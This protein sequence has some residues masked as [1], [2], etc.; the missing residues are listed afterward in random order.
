MAKQVI[1]VKIFN[2][3]TGNDATI[4]MVNGNLQWASISGFA[5]WS[6]GFIDQNTVD[7]PG[8]AINISAGGAL[9][10]FDGDAEIDVT[11]ALLHN[12]IYSGAISVIGKQAIVAIGNDPASFDD[13]KIEFNGV[14]SSQG[15]PDEI[16]VSI[17]CDSSIDFDA[18]K[19]PET[20]ITQEMALNNHDSEAIGKSILPTYGNVVYLPM[21]FCGSNSDSL[22]H[23][24]ASKEYNLGAVPTEQLF[25][26]TAPDMLHDE[27]VYDF[28]TSSL[29]AFRGRFLLQVVGIWQSAEKENVWCCLSANGRDL[30]ASATSANHL[31]GIR[32]ALIGNRLKVASGTGAGDSLLIIDVAYESHTVDWNDTSITSLWIKLDTTDI[33][34][35][36]SSL[37]Y[38]AS[39]PGDSNDGNSDYRPDFFTDKP[40]ETSFLVSA[41]DNG[42]YKN[43]V[44]FVTIQAKDDVFLLSS[45]ADI[46]NGIVVSRNNG[47]TSEINANV[48]L[49]FESEKWK[50]VSV[51]VDNVKDTDG[52]LTSVTLS[53]IQTNLF[54]YDTSF[55]GL[56]HN[57]YNGESV[58]INDSLSNRLEIVGRTDVDYSFT[59]YSTII[60]FD[61]STFFYLKD[62]YKG[63]DLSKEDLDI[64]VLPKFGYVL[65]SSA[66]FSKDFLDEPVITKIEV[67]IISDSNVVID[68]VSHTFYVG[69][70]FNNSNTTASFEF[71]VENKTV[72]LSS[73]AV[74][75]E[76]T[77][78]SLFDSINEALKIGDKLKACKSS[79][80]VNAIVVSIQSTLSTRV[81]IGSHTW[82]VKKKIYPSFIAISSQVDKN[83]LYYKCVSDPDVTTPA[84]IVKSI[85]ANNALSI[86]A[87]SFASAIT[88]QR[89]LFTLQT[90]SFDGQVQPESGS[91]ISE[92]IQEIAES[93]ITAVYMDSA[94]NVQAKF[95]PD[96]PT[97][98][99]IEFNGSNV[100]RDGLSFS[101]PKNGYVF[102]DFSFVVKA[103]PFDKES[104]ITI[105][106]DS[107]SSFPG[108]LEYDY[109]SIIFSA[110]TGYSVRSYHNLAIENDGPFT[111][112]SI[113]ISGPSRE[114]L[115]MFAVG[116]FWKYDDLVTLTT[117][118]LRID[119]V[120]PDYESENAYGVRIGCFV[121]DTVDN[122]SITIKSLS[123]R[124]PRQKWKEL[125]GGVD[126]EN[127]AIAQAMW[128]AAYAARASLGKEQ[129]APENATSL[130][131]PVWGSESFTITKWAHS[132]V[133]YC[134]QNKIVIRFEAPA[135][136]AIQ[137]VNFMDWV[138]FAWGPYSALPIRGYVVE[139]KHNIGKGTISF[140][141]LCY[142][143]YVA[144]PAIIT[145]LGELFQLET[146]EIISPEVGETSKTIGK[147]SL[148][149][150]ETALTG[151]ADLLATIPGV[152]NYR[153]DGNE[154][155]EYI[156]GIGI[157]EIVA[158]TAGQT[159]FSF[160][161]PFETD[162]IVCSVYDTVSNDLIG[163]AL[164]ITDA[165]ISASGLA[166]IEVT[167]QFRIMVRK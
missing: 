72:L 77:S 40:A 151:G 32:K 30:W 66:D 13:A 141:L 6:N 53:Q 34:S 163:V 115:S 79:K 63:F 35:L 71:D 94:G 31:T 43:D 122:A 125:V 153:I 57:V 59:S 112:R 14:V 108:E 144:I 138:S 46:G 100:I 16:T 15:F 26:A 42:K 128:G 131:N 109:G 8:Q 51:D 99:S 90:T 164:N 60:S 161:N 92:V 28:L 45:L 11:D 12:A 167:G 123:M 117:S 166:T 4:G 85:A 126:V 96:E 129:Q 127:Y 101:Q 146:G 114:L 111:F 118:L 134:T 121:L 98:Y 56:F 155:I 143:E 68:K 5:G 106:T 93:S 120:C 88:G 149:T 158:G 74:G 135:T 24:L 140:T 142:G 154:F 33:T 17:T 27:D 10:G 61:Q 107:A 52:K 147:L 64:R 80:N 97:S 136:A 103:N 73:N 156:R 50:M 37:P 148:V 2:V 76:E 119:A 82:N 84:G 160:A 1:F 55:N 20:V 95:L 104:T 19:I 41:Y 47:L 9:G 133:A 25:E 105:D 67:A 49:L 116:T 83:D 36:S 48:K 132:V 38:S 78:T 3:G 110:D 69:F 29:D 139:R 39:D 89:N 87:D 70:L 18:K 58:L 150:T 62:L 157:V 91:S 137:T 22:A 75:Y 7:I 81:D 145:E 159:S 65:S 102:S 86:G 44:S 130:K 54:N 165:T 113:G 124:S 162:Q 23:A 21:V 152:G